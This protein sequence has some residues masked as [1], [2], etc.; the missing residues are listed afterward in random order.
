[1]LVQQLANV[2]GQPAARP[3]RQATERRV[4]RKLDEWRSLLTRHVQ[5]SRQLFRELLQG[6]P[7]RLWPVEGERAFRFEGTADYAVLFAGVAGLA[8][9]MASP[10]GLS[11]LDDR[12]VGAPLRRAA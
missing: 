9:F 7:I 8:T 3:D 11:K 5:D 6:C 12:R 10:R 1:M 2:S 4:K